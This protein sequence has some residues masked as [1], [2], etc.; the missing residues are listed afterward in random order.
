MQNQPVRLF[1]RPA[2]VTDRRKVG[3]FSRG[4]QR[5][6]RPDLTPSVPVGA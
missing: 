4:D 1:K 3:L 6:L 2:P 5:R